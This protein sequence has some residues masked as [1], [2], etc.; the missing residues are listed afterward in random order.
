MFGGTT[1]GG[2]SWNCSRCGQ[3]MSGSSINHYCEP[4]WYR[5]RLVRLKAIL[6]KIK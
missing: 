5:V 6:G 3:R 1:Y 2:G 4:H